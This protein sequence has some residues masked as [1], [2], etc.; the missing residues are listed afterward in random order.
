MYKLQSG[1][2]IEASQQEK[3]IV[4]EITVST[5]GVVAAPTD[6]VYTYIADYRHHHSHF[7]PNAFSD[8]QIEEGGKGEGTV[9]RYRLKAG[10]RTQSY[11]ARIAESAPGQ[12]L[13]EHLADGK[14]VTS[15]TVSPNP[16]G[17]L[18]RIE[19]RWPGA[20]GP[21]GWMERAFAPRM[22][23]PL[24]EEELRLLDRYARGQEQKAG[25]TA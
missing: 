6:Q 23:R 1:C 21:R 4:S 8:F 2:L 18:V 16:A 15:F 25:A 9:V 24:F 12:T 3:Y 20:S 11:Q 22:L 14:T 17:S 19:T 13:E 10:G 7:L 5:E